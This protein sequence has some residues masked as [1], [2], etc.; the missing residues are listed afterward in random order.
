MRLTLQGA[1]N[2]QQSPYGP[3]CLCKTSCLA[4]CLPV[5]LIPV[6]KSGWP[7]VCQSAWPPVWESIWPPVCQSAWLHVCR[8]AWRQPESLAGHLFASRPGHQSGVL[9]D[10]FYKLSQYQVS[11]VTFFVWKKCFWKRNK[12]YCISIFLL[13]ALA[14]LYDDYDRILWILD[15]VLP[16]KFD[17]FLH[18][19]IRKKRKTN[20]GED[21]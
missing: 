18:R 15:R 5:F 21:K 7:P 11:K 8:F 12:S 6:S 10:Y 3:E 1:S 4:A 14:T 2:T 17:L 19:N 13:W 20:R 16:Y 9:T